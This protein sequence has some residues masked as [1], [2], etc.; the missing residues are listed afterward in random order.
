MAYVDQE[1]SSNRVVAI[2]VVALIHILL[3]Y[4]LVTGLA[5]KAATN[6]IERVTTVDVEEPE[7]PEPEDE[8]PPPPENVPDFVPPPVAPQPP[9]TVSNN[10]AASKTTET[11]SDFDF[12]NLPTTKSCPGGVIVDASQPCPPATRACPNGQQVPVN[13]ACP[14]P[15]K[16]RGATPRDE[17]R[18][19]RSIQ[20][21]YPA[22]ALRRD[23]SGTV[24]MR[25]TIGAN[26][27]VE[28]CAVTGSSGSDAL[29]RG[30]CRGMQRYARFN[31]AWNDAGTP[32]SAQTTRSIRY[33]LPE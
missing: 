17:A 24:T 1:M 16:A 10:V 9:I 19:A 23:E 11:I 14:E 6:I 26:G 30:A 5:Y 13:Q 2:I 32:I 20:E 8:P 12:S 4:A 27:R 15:S 25:L 3:G 33:V 29:D 22:A 7:P 31:P 18:W 28:A 21:D